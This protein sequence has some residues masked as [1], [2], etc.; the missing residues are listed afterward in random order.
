VRRHGAA[1]LVAEGGPLIRRR[2]P[3]GRQRQ[4]EAADEVLE[5]KVV[6]V[7]EAGSSVARRPQASMSGSGWL[8]PSA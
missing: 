7:L 4:G 6:G 5:V 3:S 2:Q 8:V 1:D